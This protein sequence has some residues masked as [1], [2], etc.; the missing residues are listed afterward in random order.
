M[1]LQRVGHDQ[2]EQA[3]MYALIMISD[4]YVPAIVLGIKD[5][6]VTLT[7]AEKIP[8]LVEHRVKWDWGGRK[9]INK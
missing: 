1:G 2:R 3:H 6:A 8:G 4:V 7:L 5:T 9:R